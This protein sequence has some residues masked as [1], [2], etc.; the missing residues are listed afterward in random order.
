MPPALASRAGA[1]NQTLTSC[2]P[3]SVE[4]GTI[5]CKELGCGL[6]LQAPRPRQRQKV[7]RKGQQFVACEGSG[8]DRPELQ[9]QLGKLQA[10]CLEW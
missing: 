8:A 1:P 3:Q 4:A 10:L 6:M 7:S 2:D 5:L 9:D